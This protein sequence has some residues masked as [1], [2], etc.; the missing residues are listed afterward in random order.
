MNTLAIRREDLSKKGEQRVAISPTETASL[1]KTGVKVKVQPAVHPDTGERKRAFMDEAYVDAGAEITEHIDDADVIF[2]LKEVESKF[3]R[4]G[5]TYLYFSHTHKG[6]VKNRGMLQTLVDHK[7][8]LIDYELIVD[9]QK[10][11]LVTAF[12]YFAGYAGMVDSF[13]TLG[14][15]WKSK[16][17]DTP[18]AAIKQSVAYEGGMDE[19]K[20][21]LREA[22]RKIQEDGLPASLPPLV[23][24][25]LGRGKTSTGARE[26]YNLLPVKSITLDQLAS[27]YREG[28][29]NCVYEL[30]LGIDDM[31]RQKQDSELVIDPTIHKHFSKMYR[32]HPDQ[33]ESNLDQVI[34]YTA[35]LMNCITW[36]PEFPRLMSLEKTREWHG[37]SPTLE[38]IGDITCDPEGSIQFSHETWIDEPVFTYD[39]QSGT[40]Q[41][42]FTGPGISVMAVTN[43]PCEFPADA[44]GQFASELFPFVPAF[45]SADLSAESPEAA[46]LPSEIVGATILWK[47]EFTPDYAYM[48]AFL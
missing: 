32:K 3:L 34:P 12:T 25:I 38:V 44:A 27:V 28:S 33:F 9:E 2:G 11:R 24:V 42:G 10:Q 37:A 6:Q 39:P 41:N 1:T 21:A 29:R 48:S 20:E 7:A 19:A 17:I 15:R 23:T 22:G 36:A 5:K 4:P 35:M 8:S 26:M 31:F 40:K 47:G 30:V 13:W 14:Q 46:G 18:L 43:L 45:A 16:G